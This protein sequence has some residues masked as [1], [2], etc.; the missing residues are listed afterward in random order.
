MATRAA[1]K[2]SKTKTTA[3]DVAEHLRTPEEMAAT[4]TLGSKRRLTERCGC[5]GRERG[6]IDHV[7]SR[8]EDVG[9]IQSLAS[10]ETPCHSRR[11]NSSSAHA[12]RCARFKRV[13]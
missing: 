4:W 8:A 11:S 7:C 10:K 1:A 3:Y 9:Q 6:E 5:I 13:T 12:Q 2:S